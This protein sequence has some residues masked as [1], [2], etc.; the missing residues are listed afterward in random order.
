MKTR[1]IALAVYDSIQIVRTNVYHQF[2]PFSMCES[3]HVRGCLSRISTQCCECAARLTLMTSKTDGTRK[4]IHKVLHCRGSDKSVG[5][6]PTFCCGMTWSRDVNAARNILRLGL[7]E[8]YGF[9]RPDAFLPV[10]K[11]VGV[12]NDA[13]MR[14]T[15]PPFSD[16]GNAV[17]R[18]PQIIAPSSLRSRRTAK[19]LIRNE[20]NS[21]VVGHSERAQVDA[22][23]PII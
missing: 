12:E 2:F 15:T 7:Y 9:R 21:S 6:S 11:R 23:C 18:T 5:H 1:S 20:F 22:G 3:N 17:L 13:L 8:L 14:S 4:R 19:G 16:C 10:W